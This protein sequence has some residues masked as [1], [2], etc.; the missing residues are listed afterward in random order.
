MRLIIKGR[1]QFEVPGD[2]AAFTEDKIRKFKNRIPKNAILE[3][4]FSD[5]RGP[6][7][8]KDKVCDLTMVLPG[9]KNPIHFSER[10][11]NFRKSVEFIE[12][13]LERELKRYKEERS[14]QDRGHG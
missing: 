4:E 6:K 2:L 11:E 3:L 14:Y 7:G 9:E 1:K 13:K 8:G 10:T 5:T 12:E